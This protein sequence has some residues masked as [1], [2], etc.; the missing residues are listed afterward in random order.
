MEHKTVIELID[1][2]ESILSTMQLADKGDC[3]IIK[4]AIA[5]LQ[6]EITTLVESVS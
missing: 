5:E 1:S 2:L 6:T 3:L 4:V